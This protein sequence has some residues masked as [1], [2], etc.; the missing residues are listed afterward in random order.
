MLLTRDFL[1]LLV[2]ALLIAIPIA[3]YAMQNWL[4]DFAFRV[5]ITWWM[6]VASGVLVLLI[7]LGTVS[8]QAI[9]AAMANPVKHL[10]TE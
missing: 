2:I 7:A 9:R 5:N 1:K 10:R 8:F 3:W 6:L 4:Q